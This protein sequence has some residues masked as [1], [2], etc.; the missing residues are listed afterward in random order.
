[1]YIIIYIFRTVFGVIPLCVLT[2]GAGGGWRWL[3]VV[4]LVVEEVVVLEVEVVV[5]VV[6]EVE[7][8]VVEEVVM[9]EVQVVVEV[10]H[11]V[12]Q[13]VKVDG[14]RSLQLCQR[15]RQRHVCTAADAV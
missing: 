14:R 11:E 12:K 15:R 3:V 1:M 6:V 2:E 4:E 8:A 7:L 10:E 5:E 13:E 9:L